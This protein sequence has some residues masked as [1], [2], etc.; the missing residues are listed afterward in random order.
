MTVLV[1][2]TIRLI[3]PFKIDTKEKFHVIYTPETLT[4][5]I[6]TG[7]LGNC[8]EACLTQDVKN[9][10]INLQDTKE[11]EEA[12]ASMLLDWQ[13]KYREADAS[14]VLCGAKGSLPST[15]EHVEIA[16]LLNITPTESE[17]W[18]LI[19]MDEIEREF[20]KGEED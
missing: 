19:H 10:I 8:L 6:M 12:A 1:Y 14:F 16:D 5:A 7:E 13:E 15:F 17:A 4:A 20:L 18:D 9:V 2:I 11:V 3:M